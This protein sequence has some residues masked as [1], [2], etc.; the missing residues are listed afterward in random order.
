MAEHSEWVR[1]VEWKRNGAEPETE[2]YV[3]KD[4]LR[5]HQQ[6]PLHITTQFV[7]RTK[8]RR[9]QDEKEQEGTSKSHAAPY[10][11]AV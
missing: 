9:E 11:I 2:M 4:D 7:G 6:D 8:W 1:F 10:A 5:K 3:H